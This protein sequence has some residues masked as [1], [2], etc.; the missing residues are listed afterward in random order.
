MKFSEDKEYN[1]IESF[2][3]SYYQAI[4]ATNLKKNIFKKNVKTFFALLM[5]RV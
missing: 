2:C 1:N 3:K 4:G 5:T